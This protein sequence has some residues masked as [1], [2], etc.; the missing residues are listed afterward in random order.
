MT[1]NHLSISFLILTGAMVILDVSFTIF[2]QDS[3]Y[4]RNF[5][6]VNEGNPL[7]R[8]FLILHPAVF[9][10]AF[11]IYLVVGLLLA[12]RLRPPLNLIIAMVL[13]LWHGFGACSWLKIIL[14]KIF[15]DLPWYEYNSWYLPVIFYAILGIV[16]GLVLWRQSNK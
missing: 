10:A 16:L 1:K 7:A 11:L 4:W 13:I 12:W 5:K 2:G 15:H 8:Y 3:Y 9:I 14:L 6:L